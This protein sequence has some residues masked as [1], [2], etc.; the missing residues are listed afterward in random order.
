MAERPDRQELTPL[1]FLRRSA[2]AYGDRTAVVDGDRSWTWAEFHDRCHALGRG[3]AARGVAPGERVAVLAPNG[4][5]ALEAHY[6]VAL[7]GGVLCAINTRLAAPEV[8]AIVEQSRPRLV[9]HDPALATLAEPAAA[10]VG[11]EAI[12]TGDPYEALLA[13]GDGAALPAWPDDE[14]RPIGINATSGTTGR[15]KGVVVTHRG[16]YLNALAQALDVGLTPD[17]RYLWT[18]PMFH[19]NGWCYTWAVTAAGGRHVCLPRPD[20]DAVWRHLRED[21]ITHLCA[22]PTVLIAMLAHPDAAPLERPWTVATGGAPPSPTIIAR[23]EALNGRIVHLYGLTETY[24][25][26]AISAWREEW[27]TL[28]SEDR[29]R[30]RARQGVPQPTGGDLRVVDEDGRD[31]PADA[32]T[33]GE[34]VVRG[35]TVMAGYHDDPEATAEAFRGGWFHTGD[36]AV[37]HP[38]GYVEIRDRFKDVIVSGGENIS[39]IEVEQALA[40]HPAVQEVAV[41]AIPHE[42]WGERP[43]AFVV[44]NPG[45]DAT[46]AE[47]IA[48]CREHLAGFKCPDAIEFGELPKTSTG[49]VQKHV[50]R[51]REWA[52]RT[53]RVN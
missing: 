34:I 14:E 11:A 2:L 50:L 5:V 27:D 41:V 46:A 19:C 17:T 42:R 33:L 23:V 24:G 47:L 1:L 36:A 9:I 49:K 48:F 3:L 43:K 30:L 44:L 10:A 18:L 51:E 25:P 28:E 15:P 20:P 31:V 45:A 26:A 6:G 35:N 40:R 4:H 7:A 13:S 39:T 12:P 52:G 22:A 32:A 21:G 8:A 37:V 29:A 16:G 38:D 53:V